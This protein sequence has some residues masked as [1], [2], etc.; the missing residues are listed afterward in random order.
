MNIS[1]NDDNN[2][3]KL[4]TTRIMIRVMMIK[5]CRQMDCIYKEH[6]NLFIFEK[7]KDIHDKIETKTNN[8][9]NRK[10]YTKDES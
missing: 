4:P 10:V 6:Y 5:I 3:K 8:I 7:Y 9:I 1:N 2:D